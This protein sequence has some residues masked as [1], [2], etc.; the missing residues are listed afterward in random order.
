MEMCYDG[1]LVMP[2]SYAVMSEDE[3]SY[4]EGGV[5]FNRSWVSVAV[6]VIA[7]AICPYLAPIK[8]LGKQAA[9]ALV[10]KYLPKLAGAFAKIVRTALGVS[11]NVSAGKLGSLV[12]GNAWCLTSL[13]GVVA[14]VADGVSDGRVD[15][16]IR[17]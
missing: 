15:G 12:F 1:A 16:M 10:Q 13:G 8:Y 6:D 14:L 11:I 3:M 9:K 7:M 5:T 17:I 4:V 2:S